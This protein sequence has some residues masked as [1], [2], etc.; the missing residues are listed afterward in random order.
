MDNG[1]GNYYYS[2][3]YSTLSRKYPFVLLKLA[4]GI[5]R[6]NPGMLALAVFKNIHCHVTACKYA[7]N[8]SDT[9][10][11][12]SLKMVP[13]LLIFQ[14]R[15]YGCPNNSYLVN[16]WPR[17]Q[18]RLLAAFLVNV[19]DSQSPKPILEVW[20]AFNTT[21]AATEVWDS[22]SDSLQTTCPLTGWIDRKVTQDQKPFQCLKPDF[23]YHRPQAL[24]FQF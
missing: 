24:F 19:K 10:L 12:L 6:S 23:F 15:I 21:S 14:S 17:T 13:R 3:L 16:N 1:G 20:S 4:I 9:L 11:A 2:D 8:N 5:Q 7:P 22:N 18:W